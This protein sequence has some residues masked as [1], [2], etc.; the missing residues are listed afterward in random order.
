MPKRYP[1]EFKRDVVAVARRGDLTISEVATDFGV[2]EES[3]RRW[4]RQANI[5]EGIRDGMTSA[6][7]SELVRLR[8]EK[9]RLEM[10][11][12][13]LRRSAAY[14]PSSTLP[15]RATR[16]SVTWPPKVSRCG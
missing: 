9:R 4:M 6:E 1:D 2:A 14:F 10:E 15:K 12:E 5:D 11:D 16:W 3:V 8:R 13:I 7:Q